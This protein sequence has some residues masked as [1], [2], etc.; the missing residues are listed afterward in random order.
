MSQSCINLNTIDVCNQKLC[1]ETNSFTL[2]LPLL[3]SFVN[4]EITSAGTLDRIA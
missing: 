3:D 2:G 1:N 4:I